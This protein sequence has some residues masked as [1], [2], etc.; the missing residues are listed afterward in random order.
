MKRLNQIMGI[1]FLIFIFSAI[2]LYIFNKDKAYSPMEK[3]NLAQKPQINLAGVSSG[4]FMDN[5][6][7]YM[8]DQY[9]FRDDLMHIKTSLDIGL[10][11]DEIQNVF[12]C[13]DGQL[14]ENFLEADR[15]NTL[16]TAESIK[17]FAEKYTDTK[18]YM[19]LVP[20]AIS[21]YPEKLPDN[22]EYA[23]QNEYIDL[24]NSVVEK[25]LNIVDVRTIFS[26]K[27]DEVQL[28]Y[29]TDHHW[30]S[31]G[32]RLAC[33]LLCDAMKASRPDKYNLGIV[34]NDFIGSL[35]AKIGMGDNYFVNDSIKVAVP[36]DDREI[37]YTVEANGVKK[38]SCYDAEALKGEDGYQVFFGGNYPEIT[39]KTTKQ[40]RRNLLV[41]K[42]SYA[43]SLIPMLIEEYRNITIIDPRYYYDDI[44]ML[45]SIENYDEVVFLYNV[46]TLSNDYNLKSVLEG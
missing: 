23:D 43:N 41:I 26:R 14:M 6:E 30:T 22:I 37:L 35:A 13:K 21:V 32:A 2:P 18:M 38:G 40:K 33:N 9:A 28:Y 24:F 16:E 17:K 45:M 36:C 3:R 20:N 44:N 34:S 5:V 25:S 10:G 39:I 1:V 29:M 15:K 7:K 19:M 12:I 27:K 4:D 8:A 46:N 42:D 31:D 11:S